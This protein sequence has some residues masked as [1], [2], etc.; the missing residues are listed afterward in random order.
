MDRRGFISNLVGACIALQVP[1]VLQPL[2]KT[3]RVIKWIDIKN[4]YGGTISLVYNPIWD[5]PIENW[6]IREEVI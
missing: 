4:P 2:P 6:K 1:K 3:L 5:G